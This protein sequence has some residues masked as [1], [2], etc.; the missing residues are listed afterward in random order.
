MSKPVRWPQSSTGRRHDGAGAGAG[1]SAGTGTGATAAAAPEI[2]AAADSKDSTNPETGEP[3]SDSASGGE[4]EHKETQEEILSRIISFHLFTE[5]SYKRLVEREASDKAKAEERAGKAQEAHLVDG[6][7]IFGAE[8][9]ESDKPP[10]K[11]PDLHEGSVLREEYGVFPRDYLGKPIEEID[12]GIR[13]K[14][15]LWRCG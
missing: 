6:E 8:E 10:P 3:T 5:E 7:L 12:K 9:D 13:D 14:V 1:A 4:G 11:N 2:V 15:R